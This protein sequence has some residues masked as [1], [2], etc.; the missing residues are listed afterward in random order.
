VKK[1]LY[2]IDLL[3]H[4][5]WVFVVIRRSFLSLRRKNPMK[6]IEL[7]KTSCKS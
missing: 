2:D 7:Y 1:R 6:V 5:I 4:V 3:T